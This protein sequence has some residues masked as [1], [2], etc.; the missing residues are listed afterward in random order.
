MTNPGKQP[1][2]RRTRTAASPKTAKTAKTAP[3]KTEAPKTETPEVEAAA[4]APAQEHGRQT[5]GHPVTAP[6]GHVVDAAGRAVALPVSA[7]QRILPAKG[8]LPLYAGLGALGVA[9]VLDWPV[10]VG[11]GI[12]YAVLR[13]G[14]LRPQPAA[15]S[16]AAA[17]K[18]T[19]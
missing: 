12:G 13:R 11:I 15:P 17:S 8:G 14:A 10:A 7:A 2:T 18:D 3:P 19:G 4:T 6:L 5:D 9:G 1:Q 16:P